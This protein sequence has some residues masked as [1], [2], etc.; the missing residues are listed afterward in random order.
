M[1]HCNTACLHPCAHLYSNHA[2]L[3]VLPNKPSNRRGGPTHRQ[4]N[5]L[6]LRPSAGLLFFTSIHSETRI[7]WKSKVLNRNIIFSFSSSNLTFTRQIPSIICDFFII[8][9][10]FSRLLVRRR[11][12]YHYL[13]VVWIPADVWFFY[14]EHPSPWRKS[15]GR[16]IG[17]S[18]KN[19]Y[20]WLSAWALQHCQK[21][22]AEGGRLRFVVH[23]CGKRDGALS[24]AAE[25]RRRETLVVGWK[26]IRPCHCGLQKGHKW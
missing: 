20:K 15:S 24:F 12:S 17:G 21:S 8:C 10:H 22:A 18:V 1:I 9:C 11:D 26:M 25:E 19:H 13:F 2:C 14:Q 7:A 23:F 16:G 5:V 4:A 3:R 6:Q